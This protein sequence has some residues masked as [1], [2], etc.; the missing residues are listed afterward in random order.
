MKKHRHAK[1]IHQYAD[2]AQIQMRMSDRDEWIDIPQ[3]D[4]SADFYRVKPA[5]NYPASTLTY[6]ELCNIVNDAYQ[7][8]GGEGYQTKIARLAADRAVAEFISSGQIYEWIKAN[9]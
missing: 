7:V 1:F 9:P 3:P 4:W 6:G 8:E 2:G 5:K